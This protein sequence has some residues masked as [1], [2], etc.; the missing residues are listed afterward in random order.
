MKMLI[1]LFKMT[2]LREAG[3]S[4]WGFH[5]YFKALTAMSRLQFQKRL[6]LQ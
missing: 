1:N 2:A 6:R 3:I 4:V 5:H